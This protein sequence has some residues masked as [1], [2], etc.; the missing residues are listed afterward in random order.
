MKRE[1]AIILCVA[2]AWAVFMTPAKVTW[3]STHYNYGAFRE[4]EGPRKG[5]LSFVN[6][7]DA[8]TFIRNVRPS[9]GCTAADYPRDM[10]APGD[11]ATIEFTYDPARRPGPFD[12]TIRVFVGKDNEQSVIR[13]T[14]TVIGSASTLESYYPY[15]AGALRFESL[16]HSMGEV[17]R[18]SSRHAFINVYNQGNDTLRPE[19]KTTTDAI[20]VNLTPKQ[21]APGEL[22]TFGF[23]LNTNKEKLN[24]P[25]EYLV[26]VFP[27]KG[28]SSA[29]RR[30]IKV[31]AI[32]VPDSRGMTAEEIQKGPRS[33]L[34]PEFVDFGE[35]V[36][37]GYRD[38]EFGIY[39]DGKSVLQIDRV[40]SADK[41]VEIKEYPRKVKG[42]A[43]G[44]VAGRISL[45][46]LPSGPFRINVYV[47][48][49]DPLHPLRT[50]NIVGVK[51]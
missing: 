20:D 26:E 2:A 14:G 12:K 48:T 50:A 38:F 36:A 32:I 13:I 33:Y 29:D 41:N 43:S 19:C 22:G 39:N 3:L 51:E 49:N 7:G 45:G 34:V 25:A 4:E 1:I 5:S 42:G 9:C 6:S 24:G 40:Y 37:T 11:T 44:K 31:D 8:P 17:K 28:C 15:E 16:S 27:D 10:I 30:E 46:N 18:G 21:L 47:V 35:D 23:Y